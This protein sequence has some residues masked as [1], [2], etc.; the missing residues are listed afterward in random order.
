MKNEKSRI[1]TRVN[2]LTAVL[3]RKNKKKSGSSWSGHTVQTQKVERSKN[4]P[5][6]QLAVAEFAS[7]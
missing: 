6:L 1:I 2:A 5:I 7:K 3:L 4:C